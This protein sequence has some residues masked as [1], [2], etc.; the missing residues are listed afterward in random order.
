MHDNEQQVKG[1]YM[2]E[3]YIINRESGINPPTGFDGVSDGSWFGSFKVENADIWKRIKD[4]EFKG[5]S[6]EGA[7]DHLFYVDK[8]QK[9]INQ[10]IDIIKAIEP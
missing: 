5:F 2:F 3:S 1:A 6:I 10:I 8:E 4:G 7:F 9:A